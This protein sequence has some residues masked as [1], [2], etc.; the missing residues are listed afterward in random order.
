MTQRLETV[1]AD[2]GYWHTRQM[3]NIVSDGI[4]VLVPPDAGYERAPGR[5]GTKVPTRSCAGCSPARLDTSS[6][7]IERQQSSRS[8]PRTSSTAAS[9]GSRDEAEP[10][11]A[12]SGGSKQQPTTCSSS[13]A[14][15][16]APRSP[17]QRL[18][19][20]H[21][22]CDPGS[23]QPHHGSG[24][25][26][27]LCPTATARNRTAPEAATA[28]VRASRRSSRC[29]P[30]SS[31]T[32]IERGSV[33]PCDGQGVNRG[34]GSGSPASPGGRPGAALPGLRG[35]LDQADRRPS[36]SLAG[37]GQGVLLRPDG[38][39]KRGRSRPAT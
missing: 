6:T 14:T 24:G 32:P 7:C 4:Q 22:S 1:L 5:D 37:D 31:E 23:V 9:A 16:S 34:N 8:S 10:R 17:D 20:R 25:L 26:A 29:V 19:E 3:E 27:D 35:P 15:G 11:C 39:T 33:P 38:A 28:Q 21:A 12:R 36:R 2:A 18:V 13:T 30:T